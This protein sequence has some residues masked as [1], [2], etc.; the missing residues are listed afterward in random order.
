MQFPIVL[1]L[2]PLTAAFPLELS[3]LRS[4][5]PR[6]LT[7]TTQNDL[8]NGTPCKALTVLFARGTDSPGNVGSSTGPPFFQAIASLIGADKIAVQGIDYP[9]TIL[10]FELGGDNA[11][12]ALMAKLTAQAMYVLCLVKLG[13]KN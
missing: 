12:G 9:A 10:G 2:I 7:D 4:L 11:G 8:T 3:S 13:C 6:T 5:L 1:T